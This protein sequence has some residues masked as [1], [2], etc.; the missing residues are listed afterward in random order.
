MLNLFIR[1]LDILLCDPSDVTWVIYI[2]GSP[3]RLSD[4]SCLKAV[5]GDGASFPSFSVQVS[6]PGLVQ[7]IR[8]QFPSVPASP[9]CNPHAAGLNTGDHVMSY[10]VSGPTPADV[11]ISVDYPMIISHPIICSCWEI[12][13]LYFTLLLQQAF[14]HI[15]WVNIFRDF[16]HLTF[17]D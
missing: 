14:G 4:F 16:N 13:L 10:V 1:S 7:P 6:R 2:V 3:A 12:T 8:K 11:T 17:S 5:A 15:L 9:K